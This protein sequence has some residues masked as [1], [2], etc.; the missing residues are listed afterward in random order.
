MIQIHVGDFVTD[1]IFI[2]VS[3]WLLAESV[4]TILKVRIFFLE[5]KLSRVT[6]KWVPVS[7]SLPD[8][9]TFV[10]GAVRWP[11]GKVVMFPIYRMADEGDSWQWL[12][13]DDN[14]ELVYDVNVTHWRPLPEAPK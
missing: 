3:V 12:T 2:A 1:L 5:K 8:F 9:N 13:A 7:E 10:L 11:S 6:E 14:T 4:S